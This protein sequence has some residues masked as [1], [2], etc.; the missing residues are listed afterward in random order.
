MANNL[1]AI[2]PSI[3]AGLDMVSR[4]IIGIIPAVQHDA[5]LER[6]AR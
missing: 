2:M 4:E 6:V 5:S 1:N 3:Y